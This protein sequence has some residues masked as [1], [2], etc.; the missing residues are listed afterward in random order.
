L[1]Q[2]ESGTAMIHGRTVTRSQTTSFVVSLSGLVGILAYP[3]SAIIGGY[4]PMADEYRFDA[5]AAFGRTT[6]LCGPNNYNVN[7][8]SA[9]L[10]D[11]E[12]AL[13]AWHLLSWGSHQFDD[14]DFFENLPPSGHF[15]LRFR[16]NEDGTLGA[17]STQPPTLGCESFHDVKIA[18]YFLPAEQFHTKRL[19]QNAQNGR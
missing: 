9:V 13:T 1:A 5:V 18:E 14:A 12:W 4:A 2:V 11:C 10:I 7:S 3:T 19:S 6:N 15:S 17:T 8:G 16:R